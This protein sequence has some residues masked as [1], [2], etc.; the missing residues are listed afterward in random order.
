MHR[1]R[2][3]SRVLPVTAAVVACGFASTAAVG[4]ESPPSGTAG[5]ESCPTDVDALT[6][7]TLPAGTSVAAC[8]L[9]GALVANLDTQSPFELAIPL[10]GETA[11]AVADGVTEASSAAFA[12]AVD[13]VGIISYP[14]PHGTQEAQTSPEDGDGFGSSSSTF[15]TDLEELNL[16]LAEGAAA[17][18]YDPCKDGANRVYGF[19]YRSSVQ[20]YINP[21]NRPAGLSIAD[22]EAHIRAGKNNVTGVRNNCGLG[23]NMSGDISYNGTLSVAA[24][25]SYNASTNKYTC[26]SSDSLSIVGF[27]PLPTNVLGVWC[28]KTSPQDSTTLIAG[29]IR[30]TNRANTLITNGAASTCVGRYD[31]Q[32]LAT[33]EFG[34]YFGLAHVGEAKHPTMTMSP[35]LGACTNQ[36]RT[37]GLGDIRGL[38]RLY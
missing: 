22:A 3:T 15:P 26:T 11:W 36:E 24:N 34:H 25:I 28:G 5:S 8:D 17:P 20:W 19:K 32:A 16:L 2:I 31:L 21:A 9:I 23:D 38:E 14:P 35:Q 18:Q 27:G 7:R 13:E 6:T 12:V 4:Q 10:P 37:L 1:L 33:H 29:D 30:I